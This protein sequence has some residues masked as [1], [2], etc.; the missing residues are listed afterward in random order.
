MPLAIRTV[1]TAFVSCILTKVAGVAS[2]LS[3]E[4]HKPQEGSL[5]AG[6]IYAA[7]AR[8][9]A[10]RIRTAVRETSRTQDARET[11]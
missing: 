10:L 4:F 1:N 9:H 11:R 8:G 2:R 3:H 7:L 6:Q 5:V